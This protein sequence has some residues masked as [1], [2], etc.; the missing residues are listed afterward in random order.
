MFFVSQGLS[1]T[2][3]NFKD[4]DLKVDQWQWAEAKAHVKDRNGSTWGGQL[5]SQSYSIH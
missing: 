4:R 2:D 5:S 3:A 1:L